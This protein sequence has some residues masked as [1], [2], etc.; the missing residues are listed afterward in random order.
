MLFIKTS[1]NSQKYSI[2]SQKFQ[3]TQKKDLK[4]IEIAEIWLI[5]IKKTFKNIRFRAN[6]ME[7]IQK[8]S[9]FD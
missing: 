7:N 2:I 4:I 8:H 9:I 5:M 3:N 6:L 1:K